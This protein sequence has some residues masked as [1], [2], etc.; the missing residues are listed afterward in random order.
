MSVYVTLGVDPEASYRFYDAVLATIGW[1]SRGDFGPWRGYSEGGQEQEPSLWIAP[2]FNGDPA[3]SG[4]GTMVGFMVKSR[5]EVVAFHQAALAQGG[6]DEGAPGL[7]PQYGP[8]WFAAYVR[9]PVG[10]KLAVVC[11][12]PPVAA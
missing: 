7:R 8:D 9:D 3:T 4:N 10:N 12:H 2:P 1:A 6:R 11:N 5:A